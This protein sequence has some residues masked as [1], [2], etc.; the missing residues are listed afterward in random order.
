ME[1]SKENVSNCQPL[2]SDVRGAVLTPASLCHA[3]PLAVLR[4]FV[5]MWALYAGHLFSAA[6]LDNPWMLCNE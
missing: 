3:C 1:I 2:R 4:A 5:G 6:S